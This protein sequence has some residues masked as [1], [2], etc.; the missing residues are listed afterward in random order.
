MRANRFAL[1]TPVITS[2]KGRCVA[3]SVDAY[4]ARFL[5]DTACSTWRNLFNA[6]E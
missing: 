4:R 3:R 5:R 1:I 6:N 2:T